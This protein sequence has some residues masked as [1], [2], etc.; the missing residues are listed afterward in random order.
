MDL[1]Y[2]EC[3][4]G[5]GAHSSLKE[6]GD[7]DSMDIYSGLGDTPTHTTETPSML[8]S[9]RA[10]QSMDLYEEILTEEVKSKDSSYEENTGLSS[11]NLRLKKNL[12]SLLKTARQEV[13][14]KDEEIKKLNQ[15]L[16]TNVYNPHA[17]GQWRTFPNNPTNKPPPFLPPP[18]PG[19]GNAFSTTAPPSRASATPAATPPPYPPGAQHWPRRTSSTTSSTPSTPQ[20]RW[21]SLTCSTS[22]SAA[23]PTNLPPPQHRPNGSSSITCRPPALPTDTSG[24]SLP[25]PQ[26][27]KTPSS[28]STAC[29]PSPPLTNPPPPKR[30][31]STTSST[32]SCRPPAPPT[33][34]AL[35][36]PSQPGLSKKCS[37]ISSTFTPSAPPTNPSLPSSRPL[38]QPFR[39]SRISTSKEPAPPPPPSPPV[40]KPRPPSPPSEQVCPVSL[41]PPP[42]PPV[43]QPR[44]PSPPSEDVCPYPPPRPVP[45]PR[46]PSPLS[47]EVC[48]ESLPPPPP[49]EKIRDG[50]VQ[51][52]DAIPHKCSSR[53]ESKETDKQ[54]KTESQSELPELGE[55]DTSKPSKYKEQEPKSQ[56][57]SEAT[58]KRLKSSLGPNKDCDTNHRNRSRRAE[59]ESRNKHTSHKLL[60]SS[61]SQDAEKRHSSETATNLHF[62]S[63]ER[64]QDD[65]KP[66]SNYNGTEPKESRL[67]D[68]SRENRKDKHADKTSE[69]KQS[70]SSKDRRNYTTKQHVDGNVESSKRKGNRTDPPDED[71]RNTE[72]QREDDNGRRERRSE[73]R[74]HTDRKRSKD[75]GRRKAESREAQKKSLVIELEVPTRTD[76]LKENSPTRKLKENSPTRKLCFMETLNLTLSPVKKPQIQQNDCVPQEVTQKDGK[77]D[78]EIGSKDDDDVLN[79]EEFLIIDE[80]ESSTNELEI[81]HDM[82]QSPKPSSASQTSTKNCAIEDVEKDQSLTTTET[83]RVVVSEQPEVLPVQSTVE[84]GLPQAK[85]SIYTDRPTLNAPV[86]AQES[87]IISKLP[88]E[89]TSPNNPVDMEELETLSPHE[90]E[91][92]SISEVCKCS[93]SENNNPGKNHSEFVEPAEPIVLESG[94]KTGEHELHENQSTAPGDKDKWSCPCPITSPE[95][96]EKTVSCLSP[97][98]SPVP[99]EVEKTLSCL[100]PIAGPVRKEVNKI[101]SCPCIITGPVSDEVNKK[102]SPEGPQSPRNDPLKPPASMWNPTHKGGVDHQESSPKCSDT[103]SSTI[104]QDALSQGHI[105]LPEAI[106]VLTHTDNSSGD[107][108]LPDE[109]GPSVS[110]VG[111]SKVSSTTEDTTSPGKLE[112]VRECTPVKGY[113]V[114]DRHQHRPGT[115]KDEASAEPSSSVP[116]FYDEDSM[117]LMLKNLRSI[118][119]MISPLRSPMLRAKRVL[120]HFTATKPPHVKSL[121]KDFFSTAVV[122]NSTTLKLNKETKYQDDPLTQEP[123]PVIETTLIRLPVHSD[124]VSA[125]SSDLE[126]GEILSDSNEA[127]LSPPKLTR[128]ANDDNKKNNKPSPKS[129]SRTAKQSAKETRVSSKGPKVMEALKKVRFHIRKKYMK[130]HKVFPKKSFYAMMDHFQQSFLEFVESAIFEQQASSLTF[131]LVRDTQ[132]G[133]I[134][135]CLM[136]GSDLLDASLVAGDTTSWSLSTPRKECLPGDSLLSITSPSKLLSPSKFSSPRKF[137]TPTK[138]VTSPSKLITT[139]SSVLPSKLCSPQPKLLHM[140]LNSA[141]FDESCLLEL[142]SSSRSTAQRS[143]SFL[144]EDLALSLTIPS[145]LKSDSHLSFLQPRTMNMMSTPESVISAHLGEEALLGSEDAWEQQDLHL[146]LDTDNSDSSCSSARDSPTPVLFQFKPHLSMQAVVM[147]RSNDHFIV[148][149]R[150]SPLE[151]ANITLTA[152]DSLSR[153]LTEE[154]PYQGETEPD[155]LVLHKPELVPKALFLEKSFRKEPSLPKPPP[156]SPEETI[157]AVPESPEAKTSVKELPSH[158]SESTSSA[159]EMGM[160]TAS[161]G[162][163]AIVEYASSSG[164]PKKEAMGKVCRKRKMRHEK[165]KAKRA[166]KEEE[167][168]GK[169]L[170]KVTSARSREPSSSKQEKESPPKTPP[171][172]LSAKNV[173]KKK[174]E[175]VVAWT[176]DEDRAILL[177]LKTKGASRETFS[178]LSEKINKS[179]AQIEERFSQLMKLFKKQEKIVHSSP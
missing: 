130:L 87:R 145:P 129:M 43:L 100:S 122:S 18:Q 19:A 90:A 123:Q 39:T 154:D 148:K 27:N 149:I 25:R 50:V 86:V 93:P 70:S 92:G 34:S 170:K 13:L 98:T 139:W 83:S 109:P 105:S 49:P 136:Q 59:K 2:D 174:G 65:T 66:E 37:S 61:C 166:K 77:E 171:S 41:P 48:P 169:K 78:G 111:V 155:V 63:Q 96:V 6:D 158:P 144:A 160:S 106:Y 3:Y 137:G 76:C 28:L 17:N 127:D 124:R 95:E 54:Q 94:V 24:P 179:S 107:S 56:T 21:T 161:E 132:M 44:P 10:K 175:V 120:A 177:D 104:T 99:E 168:G 4:D 60:K 102:G 84:C 58:D 134:F 69:K 112:S 30:Q 9:P 72:R 165:T 167:R 156:P 36:P 138:F 114:G 46:P 80:I 141:M 143:Y 57:P 133:E 97:I 162:R 7:E 126:E 11:E 23:T 5:S 110:C 62:R 152:D 20:P 121:Q 22:K 117:M 172:S 67:K 73:K 125:S 173:V 103:V 51:Q 75:E 14:R 150:Q 101:T 88:V 33:E 131:N 153:T 159:D 128:P 151:S 142:P 81:R 176:R 118:P 55:L 42:P 26:P 68:S 1:L 146:A 74:R 64:K 15:R 108:I 31:P 85:E 52:P 38:S 113:G 16:G 45:Q 140:P 163:L 47:E 115:E 71:R 157:P 35:P 12:S 53:L 8:F 40:L 164:T 116:L 135:K 82:E 91:T 79:L 29:K 178:I 147:E 119:N 32:S 89:N